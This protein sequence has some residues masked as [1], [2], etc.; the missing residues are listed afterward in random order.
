M[1]PMEI[2]VEARDGKKEQEGETELKPATTHCVCRVTGSEVS[3]SIGDDA[4][5]PALQLAMMLRLQKIA[6]R[7]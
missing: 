2:G 5:F 7:C 4:V 3:D 6:P 1:S